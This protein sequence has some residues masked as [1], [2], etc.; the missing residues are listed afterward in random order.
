MKL[1]KFTILH[2]NDMHGDFFAENCK[3]TEELI[4]GIAL[5]SGYINKVRKK[6]E[7]VLYVIAGDMLQGSLID[8]EYKGISTMEIMNYLS[9]DVVCIGNHEVDYGLPQLLFLERVANF[10]IVN[11]NL[12]MKNYHKRLMKPYYIIKQAGI[13]ILFTGVIT[14]K[15]MDSI[16][17]DKLISSFVN[18]EDASKEIGKICNAYKNDDIDLTVVLSHIG[19]ESDIELAK[20]LKKDWGV[21]LIFGG[22]SHTILKH[23]KKV[24]NIL[25]MQAGVGTNQIGRLDIIIDEELNK[26]VKYKWKL[27]PI[28]NKI[29]Q[30]DEKLLNFINSY[31]KSVDEKYSVIIS[32]LGRIHTHPLR[33]VETEL[34]NLVADALHSYSQ[35]DISLVG[36]GSI[37]SETLGPI[38]TLMDIMQCFPFDDTWT[39]YKI[40][41]K[42]LRKIFSSIMRNEN[43][44]GEGECYQVNSGINAVFDTKINS[45]KSLSI[46]GK[47]VREDQ[48]YT[49][50]IQGYH[51]GCS[52]EYL[53]VSQ[54]Q[55]MQSKETKVISTST[56]D[57]IEE[58]LRNNQ[59]ISKSVE[60]R[61]IYL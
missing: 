14:E 48:D 36:S 54:K 13:E 56:R 53:N 60:G 46:N 34:G 57:L 5:L 59:N 29:A 26:V 17:N 58:F 2:S 18:L 61:L 33:E 45:L 32:K 6:E 41:G 20:L 28:N 40:N 11:A 10:P 44:N 23:P 37:R 47:Y 19:F 31:K 16:K 39:R 21:D 4:G 51:F 50:C 7:N 3:E 15:I 43:R 1:K 49:I 52:K 12:Y 30:P 55:L 25:I 9:P 24:N 27:I 42:Y 22:H 35:C 8:T 38:V